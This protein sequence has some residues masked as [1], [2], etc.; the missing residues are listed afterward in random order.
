MK[1]N[2]KYY[3]SCWVVLLGLFN[4]LAFIIPAWQTLEKYTPSFWIGYGTTIGAFFGQL[5]CAWVAFKEISAKKTFYNISLFTISYAGLVAV[6][7]VSMI[8]M[9]ATPLP[10]WIAAIACA[11][12]LGVNIIAVA[13]AE[14][15]IELV[16]NADE[17]IEKATV[18]IYDMRAESESLFARA[19][20][21]DVKAICKKVC[22]AFKY[23]DPMSNAELV[24]IEVE[25][26]AHFDLLK[27]AVTEGKMD[28]A[29]SESEETL[30]LIAD[31]NNKCKK[32]K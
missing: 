26:K 10:Y 22:D 2:F 19:K 8:C 11:V 5:I 1:K 31:R 28:V 14:M 27:K 32:F 15:A 30:A 24:S 29:T 23:S 18:F 13:K 20:S 4:L 7:A 25:I 12:V 6:F 21:G 9:I 16:K 3:I 17:K